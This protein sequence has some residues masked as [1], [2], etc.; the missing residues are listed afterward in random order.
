MLLFQRCA[1]IARTYVIHVL[2][3]YCC[4]IYMALQE[5]CTEKYFACRKC[6][7]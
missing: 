5:T 3:M 1:A 6:R 4:V 7:C 2:L